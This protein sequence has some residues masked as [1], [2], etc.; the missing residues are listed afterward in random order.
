MPELQLKKLSRRD[1]LEMLIEQGRENDNLK[2]ALQEA[3]NRL[4]S[5]ELTMQNAGSMAEAALVLNEVYEAADAAAKQFLEN[6]QR[7]CDE[8]QQQAD[9]IVE[10]ARAKADAIL[11]QTEAKCS[12]MLLTEARRVLQAAGEYPPA[13]DSQSQPDTQ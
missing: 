1:L 2:A 3:A 10:E 6:V 8:R 4:K 12:D 7:R 11:A 5:R 9:A 13:S